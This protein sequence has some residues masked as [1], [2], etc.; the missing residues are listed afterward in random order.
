[1]EIICTLSWIL[2]VQWLKK[3]AVTFT[4]LEICV[5]IVFVP[6]FVAASAFCFCFFVCWHACNVVGCMISALWDSVEARR[7]QCRQ[8]ESMYLHMYRYFTLL[9]LVS[10]LWIREWCSYFVP[11]PIETCKT[12]SNLKKK[13]P[14]KKSTIGSLH[15]TQKTLQL[16]IVPLTGWKDQ[17]KYVLLFKKSLCLSPLHSTWE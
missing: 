4:L 14:G 2:C 6:F 12:K 1:M 7:G 9:G 5:R 11:I 16:K 8:T 13:I 3:Y 10:Y 15:Q 17:C